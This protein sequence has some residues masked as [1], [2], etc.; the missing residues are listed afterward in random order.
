[1]RCDNASCDWTDASSLRPAKRQ[2]PPPPRS[3]TSPLHSRFGPY[4][5][6]AAVVT[7][8]NEDEQKAG[9]PEPAL[10]VGLVHRKP[11]DPLLCV[12]RAPTLCTTESDPAKFGDAYDTKA[13]DA[14]DDHTRDIN[15]RKWRWAYDIPL[16]NELIAS[17]AVE[18]PN[19]RAEAMSDPKDWFLWA[20][21]AAPEGCVVAGAYSIQSIAA[22]DTDALTGAT[23]TAAVAFDHVSAIGLWDMRERRWH[24]HMPLTGLSVTGIV[25]L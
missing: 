16:P 7:L 2:H 3:R 22:L 23:R 1:M 9:A 19:A 4:A 17:V 14:K 18:K 15:G 10:I 5:F 24:P 25:A 11:S 13:E 20:E 8:A 6:C 21:R 12:L